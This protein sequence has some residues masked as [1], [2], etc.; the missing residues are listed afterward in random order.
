MPRIIC[1]RCAVELRCDKN[2]VP[3]VELAEFGPYRIFGSDRWKCPICEYTVLA[4]FSAEWHEHYE[5][6][7]DAALNLVRQN[8]DTVE[9]GIAYTKEEMAFMEKTLGFEMVDKNET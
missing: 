9:F 3:A 2:G 5:E 4:G 1:C 7:F 8:E 6:H